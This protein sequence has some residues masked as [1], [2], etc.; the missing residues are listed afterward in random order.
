MSQAEVAK[1]IM[2]ATHS[3]YTYCSL[4]QHYRAYLVWCNHCYTSI[5]V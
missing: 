2:H 4:V 5:D 3:V 1:H